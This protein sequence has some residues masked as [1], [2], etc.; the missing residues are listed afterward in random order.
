MDT[1]KSLEVTQGTSLV[2]PA[3]AVYEPQ[4][5]TDKASNVS[6][7][8]D[9]PYPTDEEWETLPKVPGAIPWTAVS[10]SYQCKDIKKGGKC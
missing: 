7:D 6:F 8:I 2:S 3:V 9:R 10:S 1:K 5:E 4:S